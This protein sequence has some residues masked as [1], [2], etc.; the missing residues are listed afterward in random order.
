MDRYTSKLKNC[1]VGG[2]GS[3][4]RGNEFDISQPRYPG[5]TDPSFLLP[6]KTALEK[7][8]MS[9]NASKNAPISSSLDTYNIK[10]AFLG[11]TSPEKPENIDLPCYRA[12]TIRCSKCGYDHEVQGYCSDRLCPDCRK[13]KYWHLYQGYLRILRGKSNLV[14]LVL[15]VKN[16]KYF[17][18]PAIKK[19][20]KEFNQL[21]KRKIWQSV[22]GGMY[23]IQVSEKGKGYHLHLH[24]IIETKSYLPQSVISKQWRSI[25]GSY[26][27]NI[28]QVKNQ[29]I[30]RYVLRDFFQAPRVTDPQLWADIFS[31]VRMVH[32]FGSWFGLKLEKY[33]FVCP[34]C[35]NT[36]WITEFE[37][38]RLWNS[39]A[40]FER[41]P[42]GLPSPTFS[43][44]VN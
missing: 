17:N 36:T 42:P 25:T 24:V 8:K 35:G 7:E 40:E 16:L 41:G 38:E 30:L 6:G 32:T 9:K 11:G 14:H 13:R 43:P 3:Q 12:I 1:Q 23:V 28:K 5:Q 15:T 29:R 34:K 44:S 27:V 37:L 39:P 2:S 10:S 19:I 31:R 26:V 21:R 18:K 22:T 33:S 20:R 4:N